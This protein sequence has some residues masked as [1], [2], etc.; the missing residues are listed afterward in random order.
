MKSN[1]RHTALVTVLGYILAEC[2]MVLMD[3]MG[4]VLVLMENNGP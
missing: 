4:I 1:E 3:I 2:V